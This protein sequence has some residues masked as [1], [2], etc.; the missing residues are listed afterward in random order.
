MLRKY[1]KHIIWDWNGTILD[2]VEIALLCINTMLR[3][4]KM[5]E[6]NL[7]GYRR[8]FG[9]P[10]IESYK[11]LG[12][13]FDSHAEWDA[14]SREFHAYYDE[15]SPRASLTKGV[16]ATLD[17]I[18]RQNIP[19]SILSASELVSLEAMLTKH[20][21]RKYFDRVYGLSDKY[22]GSKLELGRKL[23]ADIGMMP[24]EVLYIGDTDHDYEVSEAIGCECVLYLHGHQD[25]QR[26]GGCDCIK[27]ESFA[28]LSICQ[29]KI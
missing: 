20:G 14:V 10:V 24:C 15:S 6:L 11:T 21:I 22:G 9:F 29:R 8:I 28:E 23:I 4:R 27:I 25:R 16:V 1:H 3:K 17:G 5:A 2:D 18:R 13:K 19:M 26:L 12:F 7:E